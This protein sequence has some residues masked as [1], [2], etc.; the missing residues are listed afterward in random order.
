MDF[1]KY[2]EAK[3]YVEFFDK[4]RDKVRH[5]RQFLKYGDFNDFGKLLLLRFQRYKEEYSEC[6]YLYNHK[7]GFEYLESHL[8][9]LLTNIFETARQIR[10]YKK[11]NPSI[12]KISK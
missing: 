5:K 11:S 12:F 4:E 7:P 2:K 9:E 8:K 3:D 6:V 1:Q 10:M